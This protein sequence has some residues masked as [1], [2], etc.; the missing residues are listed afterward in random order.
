MSTRRVF[1][2][3]QLLPA[4]ALAGVWFWRRREDY[5]TAHPEIVRR[6]AARAAARRH[7]KRAREA[8][9]RSDSETFVQS[10][11]A[12]I[13]AATA[14]LDSTEAESLVLH[15]VLEKIPTAD[16]NT[17]ARETIQHLF[18]R[19]HAKEFSG[20]PIESNGVFS[21]L[22]EVER[23]ITTIERRQP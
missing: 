10:S 2:L 23:T 17:K 4:A 13:R 3:A 14:P 5:L 19:S 12:A 21:L 16:K 8:V 1:W 15:E 18:E 9:R 11:I 7:L 20:H 6:R 22:P